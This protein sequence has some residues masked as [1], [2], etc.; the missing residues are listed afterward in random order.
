MPAIDQAYK[1]RLS[2]DYITLRDYLDERVNYKPAKTLRLIAEAWVAKQAA[3][4]L[5][6]RFR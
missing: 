5:R 6:P 4:Q 1:T 3:E 2:P